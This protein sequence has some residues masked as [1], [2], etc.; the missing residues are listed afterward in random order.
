MSAAPQL[1]TSNSSQPRQAILIINSGSRAGTIFLLKGSEVSI[2]RASENNISLADDLKCSRKH[3]LLRITSQGVYIRSLNEKNLVIVDQKPCVEELLQEKCKLII[4]S[5]EFTFETREI[6]KGPA[7]PRVVK[8][9]AGTGASFQISKRFYIY[10]V[11]A[12]LVTWLLWP[13]GVKPKVSTIRNQEQIDADIAEA[14]QLKELAQKEM[15]KTRDNSVSYQQAQETYI[16]GFRDYK[17]G[18]YERA[19]EQFQ[20]CL[21]LAPQHGLCNR[22][23][24][25]SHRKFNELIQQQMILGRK[26][27]DQNQFKAC[28]ASYRNV[29]VTIKDAQN[30]TYKE[31]K[32]NYDY[33]HY[34]VEG[35][36]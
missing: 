36:Y 31:A 7:A 2:G 5:T 34:M 12:L 8:K 11:L 3:A 25:L 30:V 21:S 14:Q 29:M 15:S 16:K 1:L 28:I 22:Y 35:R 13:S 33:C 20:A 6:N 23:L 24:R 27:R 32:T 10:G 18:Q 9:A 26:Y 17:K 19:L 4:G